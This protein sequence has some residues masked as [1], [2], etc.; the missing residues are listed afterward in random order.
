M[1]SASGVKELSLSSTV[2]SEKNVGSQWSNFYWPVFSRIPTKCKEILTTKSPCFDS[3][4]ALTT[5]RQSAGD[6]SFST[7]AR[8]SIIGKNSNLR[9]A[10][11]IEHP[12]WLVLL[13]HEYNWFLCTFKI[14]QFSNFSWIMP[15]SDN[16]NRSEPITSVNGT[17]DSSNSNFSFHHLT[18][19][20][21]F[22]H[23]SASVICEVSFS[24]NNY[25]KY[26]IW[27]VYDKLILP[28]I[29]TECFK[30]KLLRNH[31][32]STFA[33]FSILGNTNIPYPLIRTRVSENLS[34]VLIGWFPVK[35]V[36]FH[37]VS[38]FLFML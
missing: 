33:K 27:R 9:T 28:N 30:S 34:Y 29:K 18:G 3:F 22:A 38:K 11:I 23:I 12:W 25:K 6:H 4:H 17:I 35:I 15:D 26:L 21:S 16:G 19:F 36:Q 8:F 10:F 31:S 1:I 20:T 32:F 5:W 37:S 2:A 13:E 14:F 24:Q 7:Y